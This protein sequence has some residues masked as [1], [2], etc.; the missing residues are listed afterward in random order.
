VL[1]H[2]SFRERLGHYLSHITFDHVVG[3]SGLAVLCAAS[4]LALAPTPEQAVLAAL[5][6]WVSELGLNVLAGVLQQK[7]QDLLS[8]PTD[9][10]I[11]RLARLA[12]SLTK[13]IRRQAKL[14]REVGKFL[15]NLSAFGI[16]EEVVRGNPAVHGWLLVQIYEDITQYRGDFDQIHE[17]LAEIRTLVQQL[18]TRSAPGTS[19]S[20]EGEKK[21]K[22]QPIEPETILAISKEGDFI[23][24]ELAFMNWTSEGRRAIMNAVD[25]TLAHAFASKEHVPPRG[26]QYIESLRY[27]FNLRQL[28]AVMRMSD[29]HNPL[30]PTKTILEG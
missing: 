1:K 7:Y 8:Q 16:A 30:P 3:A 19:T 21:S 23:D 5:T 27:K 9:D 13:D 17:T 12:G 20:I 4:A 18:E 2:D 24:V 26:N 14:R 28:I 11:N 6:K 25:F 10:D 29:Y 15:D 22:A